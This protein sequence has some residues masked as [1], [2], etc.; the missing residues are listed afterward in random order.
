MEVPLEAR[1]CS[2]SQ[3]I[4]LTKSLKFQQLHRQV[5]IAPEP[6]P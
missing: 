6:K 5:L 1:T 2:E 3:Q 4:L